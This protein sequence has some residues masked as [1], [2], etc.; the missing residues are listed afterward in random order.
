MYN[1]AWAMS[2][3]RFSLLYVETTSGFTIQMDRW[4]TGAGFA[5]KGEY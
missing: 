1:E 4:I 5:R 3:Y 2:H